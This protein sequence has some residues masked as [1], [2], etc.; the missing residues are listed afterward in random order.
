MQLPGTTFVYMYTGA[1]ANLKLQ[2]PLNLTLPES[3][4]DGDFD[5]NCAHLSAQLYVSSNKTVSS[6][7][8]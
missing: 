2:D 8:K 5:L 6:S 3:F 4:K 1:M 7:I